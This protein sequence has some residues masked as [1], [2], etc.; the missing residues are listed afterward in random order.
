M[1]NDTHGD[2]S[3]NERDA[4]FFEN[5][6]CGIILVG[7]NDIILEANATM[8]EWLDMPRTAL[9]GKK[10]SELLNFGG[11]IA[12]ETHVRPMLRMEGRVEELAFDLVNAQG[13]RVPFM[14]NAKEQRSP[15]GTH[16]STQIALFKAID[17]RTYERALLDAKNM[18]KSTAAREQEIAVFRER[19]IALLGH[20]L[21]NPL[22]AIL[23]GASL[24]DRLG[25]GGRDDEHN[26][27]LV[28]KRQFVVDGIKS[29]AN[30]AL[31]LVDDLLDMAKGRV[32]AEMEIERVA[33]A[34]LGAE[35]EKLV[36]EIRTA[37]PTR[38]FVSN[39]TIDHPVE[40]DLPRLSQLLANLLSNAHRHGDEAG[41]VTVTGLTTQDS[42]KLYVENN[43]E[44]IPENVQ[45]TLFEPFV[46]GQGKTKKNGLGLGLFIVSQVAKAHSGQ[47]EIQ[48]DDNLIRF[49]F[50]MPRLT[51]PLE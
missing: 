4:D 28:N 9:V 13:D 42:F 10:F 32:G 15:N 12:F 11:R 36:N 18:A 2:T 1:M 24:L 29:S 34:S 48:C 22:S 23:S 25:Q 35:L 51:A 33:V 45:A 7:P 17:R 16:I 41:I 26:K 27:T 19:F 44:A 3:L 6:P 21:R 5:F 37:S 50:S 49:V 46:Q 40:V 14:A 38:D 31:N 30:R 43:G 8:A 20:D 47:M 39:W